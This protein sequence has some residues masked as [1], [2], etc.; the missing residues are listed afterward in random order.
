MREIM[1]RHG[2]IRKDL[3]ITEI[4]WPSGPFGVTEKEQAN[5]LTRAYA[6][7]LSHRLMKVFWFN[8]NDWED[9]PWEGGKDAHL[10][11]LD[12]KYRLKP[13]ATAYNITEFMMAEMTARQVANHGKAVVH[14]Y[15]IQTHSYKWQGTMHIAWT[16]RMGDEEEIELDLLGGGGIIVIDY[17]GAE[18]TPEFVREHPHEHEHEHEQGQVDFIPGHANAAS[19]QVAHDDHPTTKTYRLRITDEP[20]YVWDMGAPPARPAAAD[21]GHS[22]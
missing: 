6:I 11:L 8:L 10:G 5:F 1:R 7:A 13:A 22:H 2:I 3:W 15:D 21:H 12:S 16:P 9:L 17:L 18:H 20:L 4:G 19:M 14:S